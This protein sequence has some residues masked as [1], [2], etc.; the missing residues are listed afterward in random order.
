ML[1]ERELSIQGRALPFSDQDI[2]N[3][4]YKTTIDGMLK[5]S[6]DNFD[7]QMTV[8]NIFLEDK[9]LDIVHDLKESAYNFATLQG[10]FNDRF[11]LRYTNQTLG[12][13]NPE[14]LENF[15]VFVDINQQIIVHSAVADIN[16]VRVFDI[17]GRLLQQQKGQNAKK[18]ILSGLVSRNQILLINIFTQDGKKIVK[19]IVF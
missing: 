3:L 5:I 18:I 2:V 6:I 16:E 19:K 1:D 7:G 8:S 10:T 15:S 9:L 12:N 14:N 13:S 17:S 11:S 4:G